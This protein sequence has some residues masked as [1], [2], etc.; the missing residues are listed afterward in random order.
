MPVRVSFLLLVLA[1][2]AAA[3]TPADTDD[4]AAGGADDVAAEAEG[5]DVDEATDE[6][7]TE[8]AETEPDETGQTEDPSAE[9]SSTSFPPA[10][11]TPEGPVDAD[12]QAALEVIM[13]NPGSPDRDAVAA[14][15]RSEDPRVLWV[16]SDLIRFSFQEFDYRAATD[17]ATELSGLDLD[18]LDDFSWGPLTDHL[19]AWDLPDFPGYVEVKRAIFTSFED[20]WEPFFDDDDSNID[21]R[22]TSWGGVRIDDRPL[23]ES[24]QGCPEG[25][26]P[27]LDEPELTP[28]E[29]G[30]WY[31]DD[32]IVFGVQIG[33]ETVA[34]PRNI[35]EVHEMV[36][37][38]I[39]GRRIAMPY[40]TLCGA[41]QVFF[42]DT[43]GGGNG[44]I[45]M[46]TSGLLRRS[47][48][49]MFD[50]T[51]DS[52]FD[53]F[54]GEAISGPLLDEGMVLEQ[55]TV[56]TSTWAEWRAAHPDTTI[57]ASDGGIG[58]TYPLDPL[59]GR[60]DDGPIF[61]IGETDDRLGVQDQVVGIILP[62]GTPVAFPA[63]AARTALD[64]GEAVSEGGVTLATDGAGLTAEF[65]G[66]A[67]PSHQ[68]FWFAWSQFHPDTLL[69]EA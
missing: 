1:V 36:N 69:W 14:L 15:G 9:I 7:Q 21:W 46:R 33:D 20:G 43:E 25:C 37:A 38:T 29:E 67:V 2:I 12:T 44:D 24:P 18:E 19:I 23:G 57:V 30:S 32:G 54:T 68:A 63:E 66:E 52:V 31:P 34:F 4:D 11:P 61:P 47:N 6:A 65:E 3:C 16:L 5:G 13:D 59:R 41:A 26:I 45:V 56:V 60:D 39:G 17:A 40:C 55:A 53:T 50:L 28:A 51:T 48:K 35:M 22:L 27:S 62:D 64:D 8:P 49:V 58:R 42:T 10:P